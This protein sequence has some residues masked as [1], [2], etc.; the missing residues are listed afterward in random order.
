MQRKHLL[1]IV[2]N[3]RDKSIGVAFSKASENTETAI[4]IMSLLKLNSD[5]KYFR[6]ANETHQQDR[7]NVVVVTRPI[8]ATINYISQRVQF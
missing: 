7:A 4:K 1:N 8:A 6:L 5:L 2:V 3:A